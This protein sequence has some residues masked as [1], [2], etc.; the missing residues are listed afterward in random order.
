M[1]FSDTLSKRILVTQSNLCVGLDPRP[2]LSQGDV[3]SFLNQVIEETA[4][5]AAAFKPNIAYFEAMG[6]SGYALLERL[7]GNIPREVPIVLDVKRSDIPETQ[8]YYAEAYFERWDVA[9]VTLNPFLGFDS[10]EPFLQYEGKGVYLLGVTSN[11]GANELL[12]GTLDGTPLLKQ[13]EA[14]HDRASELPGD[15][16]LVL[17]LTNLTPERLASVTDMPLLIPGLGAQGG[18][19]AGQG[20]HTRLA[21]VLINSSR[22]ILYADNPKSYGERAAESAHKIREVLNPEETDTP[23]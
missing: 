11:P 14:M 16:G 12:T 18:T 1:N 10:I 9:A 15:V 21:P 19:L 4:P 20:L 23:S 2:S 8:K 13:V 7:V 5:Y 17:G 6:S 3:E 22:S